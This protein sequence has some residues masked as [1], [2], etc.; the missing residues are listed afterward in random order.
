MDHPPGRGAAES[1]VL[2]TKEVIQD[3]LCHFAI[4]LA[5]D[6]LTPAGVSF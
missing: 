3:H 2:T 4:R 5:P 6:L 1:I